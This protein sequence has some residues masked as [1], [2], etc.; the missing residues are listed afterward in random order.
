MQPARETHDLGRAEQMKTLGWRVGSAAPVQAVRED[1]AARRSTYVRPYDIRLRREIVHRRRMVAL[2]RRFARVAS[3]HLVDGGMVALAVALV[4]RGPFVAGKAFLPAILAIVLLSLNALTAYQPG[5][6]RRDGGRVFAAVALASLIL[7]C[8]ATFDPYLPLSPLFLGLLGAVV[9]LLLLGGRKATDLLVRQ[10]YLRGIG[11]RRTLL[12]GNLDQVGHAIEQVRD[13][14]NVDQFL[15]GHLVPDGEPDPTAIGPLS[16]LAGVVESLDIQE[17]ILAS[18]L[19]TEEMHRVAD[20]CFESGI[21]LYVFPS[22]LGEV[23]CRAEPQRVGR[24]PL[25]HLYPARMEIPALMVKRA[26]DVFVGMVAVLVLAPLFAAIAL[27]IKLDSPG[28]VIFR[29]R[30]VGLGGRSFTLLKFRSMRCGA[31]AAKADLCH[32][33][34]YGDARLFKM[35]DDPRVTRVG[36]FLRRSS[37]DELPQLLNVLRGEMSLVGPR[38]PLPAEVDAYEPHHFERIAVV[39]GITGPWQ[40]GGR[41]LITDFEQVVRLERSYIRSW[42]L[43]LD[44]KILLRTVRVVIRGEG[45]F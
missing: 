25:L 34:T 37:L 6:A 16:E 32:L 30:R 13:D 21:A 23:S 8:L 36:R 9:F 17:V 7:L 31:D 28:P 45:A 2:G 43:V 11:L 20:V 18:Q 15:V 35:P 14:H 4:A 39:P 29:Q 10:V 5:D 42:S 24:C 3:L 27:A 40:V 33:N 26:F 38:P 19:S 12:I 1:D 44:A 41:N 22:L